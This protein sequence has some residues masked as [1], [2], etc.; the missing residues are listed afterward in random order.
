VSPL[1]GSV[2]S[3]NQ[4]GEQ[5]KQDDA[6]AFVKWLSLADVVTR[7]WDES[8]LEY[9]VEELVIGLRIKR[10][11]S[12]QRLARALREAMEVDQVV[13]SV[14]QLSVREVL[15][16]YQQWRSISGPASGA[17]IRTDLVA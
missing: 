11:Q 17:V 8:R 7:M 13:E 9:V 5:Q 16:E 15:A 3:D 14:H 4:V 1:V 2:V 12:A 10:E 6:A